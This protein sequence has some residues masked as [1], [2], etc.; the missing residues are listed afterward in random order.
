MLAALLY[1]EF[2]IAVDGDGCYREVGYLR[3]RRG[4]ISQSINKLRQARSLYID[5]HSFARISHIPLQA[6]RFGKVEDVR[7]ETDA[8]NDAFD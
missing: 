3:K 8:L 4:F 5:E 7:T 2:T 6:K 1:R